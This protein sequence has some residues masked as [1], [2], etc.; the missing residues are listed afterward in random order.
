[1]SHLVLLAA[2]ASGDEGD[3]G[4]FGSGVTTATAGATATSP[5][6]TTSTGSDSQ[7][8]TEGSASASETTG[9][10]P[11]TTGPPGSTSTGGDSSPATSDDATSLPPAAD[12]PGEFEVCTKVD[13]LLVVDASASMADALASL[14]ATF[15]E[16]QATLALEVGEGI[17]DF[18]I[19]VINACPA[20]P[21]FHNYGAGD[22][23]CE[24]PGGR[25]WLASD[26]PAV[27]Q[28][29][30]CVAQLPDQDEALGENGGYNSIPD[31]CDDGDDEDEQPAWTAARAL[32]PA[33]AVNAGFSRPDSV[34]FVVAITDEDEA[35]VDP[36][37]VAEIHD[38]IVAAKGEGGRVVFLGIGG[39]D[40]GCDNAYGGG[41]VADS[42]VLRE[43]ADAFGGHGMY[44]T[45]C[46]KRGDDPIGDAFTEALTTLVDAACSSFPP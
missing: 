18:H 43:V 23:D 44:R 12:M 32:S 3:A 25:N 4:G 5:A 36:D 45:M 27:A 22:T 26:D 21:N 38:A 29:F 8:P 28:K 19:A 6:T 7:V 20:P 35:L 14:P 42:K 24:F 13:V 41:E 15:A 17:D 1:M 39:D 46:K 30:A 40:G 11:T 9:D 33:V 34:L 2:C 37:D 16:I 31:T 10:A